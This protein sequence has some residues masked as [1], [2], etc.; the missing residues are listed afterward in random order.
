MLF[1]VAEQMVGLKLLAL[2]SGVIQKLPHMQ[3]S[4][5]WC[6]TARHLAQNAQILCSS[7]TQNIVVQNKKLPDEL[8]VILTAG[9]NY[10][11]CFS[12]KNST[13]YYIEQSTYG[14]N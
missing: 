3:I 2:G 1:T 10:D 13:I 4:W 8:V 9:E 7:T 5:I 11:P 6:A 14:R 12:Y